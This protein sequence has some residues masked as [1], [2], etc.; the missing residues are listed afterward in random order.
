MRKLALF[1]AVAAA[2][3][4]SVPA[5][6]AYTPLFATSGGGGIVRGHTLY[7]LAYVGGNTH[8]VASPTNGGTPRSL[9]LGGD[10]YFP[11][12]PGGAEGLSHDGK[13]ILLVNLLQKQRS[14]A[15]TFLVVDP[16][17]MKVV[18]QLTP[19]ANQGVP[20]LLTDGLSPDASRLFAVEYTNPVAGLASPCSAEH[21]Y[22]LNPYRD[23][24]ATIH[25]DAYRK[26]SMG[27]PLTRATTPDGRWDYTL[28]RESGSG[29]LLIQVL[30]TVGSSVHCVY[31]PKG[32]AVNPALSLSDDDRTLAVSSGGPWLDVAVG[33]WKITRAPGVFPWVLLGS[34]L[35]GLG[36][37]ASGGWLFRRWQHN[38]L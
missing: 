30:D 22:D 12:S 3:L 36:L 7:Y 2:A 4:G 28:Y 37:L 25:T 6:A 23:I 16:A 34:V 20:F 32:H 27:A 35:G 21:G 14:T 1:V 13:T 9:I 19:Y 11:N 18:R 8:L 24:S 29:R 38:R 26:G 31:L 15:T 10:W 5:L 33:S 17:R